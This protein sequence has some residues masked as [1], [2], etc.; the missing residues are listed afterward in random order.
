[1]LDIANAFTTQGLPVGDFFQRPNVG[2]YIP[3]YQREYSWDDGNID[4]LMEDIC[5]GVEH[6]LEDDA[7]IRFLGTIIL[8]KERNPRQNIQPQDL[9][10]LPDSIENIIDGQQRLSTIALLTCLLYEHFTALEEKIVS[11]GEE[12]SELKETIG[13]TKSALKKIFSVD[14]DRGT[15]PRKPVIIRGTKDCWTLNGRDDEFYSSD[16]SSYLAQFIT[17][18]ESDDKGFPNYRGKTLVHDN[19][20]CMNGWLT[21]VEKAHKN[22]SDD[23][24]FVPAKDILQKISEDYIWKYPRPNLIQIVSNMED[25]GT[26]SREW[27]IICSSVQLLAFTHFLLK[28]CCFTTIEPVSE[29]WAF[30]MFQSLN[31]SGTP[32]TAI[33]TF[34]PIV[35]N[36]VGTTN[37]KNSDFAKNLDMVDSFLS[38]VKT[39]EKLKLTN[40]FL[41]SFALARSGYKLANQFSEQRRWLHAQFLDCTS[42]KSKNDFIR[43][44][45]VH[46]RFYKDIA[47]QKNFSGVLKVSRNVPEEEVKLSEFLLGYLKQANHR[48]A[49]TILSRFYSSIIAE[50]EG[51]AVEFIATVKAIAAF[52]TLWRAVESNAGLDNVYRLLLKGDSERE[53]TAFSWMNNEVDISSGSLCEY[54]KSVLNDKN[55][56]SREVWIRKA[57]NYLNYDRKAICK[58]VLFLVAQDSIADPTAKG[59][60]KPAKKGATPWL[61][62]FDTWNSKDYSSLEHIAPQVAQEQSVWD[63]RIYEEE[64]QHSI[65]NLTLLPIEINSSIGNKGWLEKYY[66]YKHLSLNDFDAIS[67]LAEKARENEIHLGESTL[68]RLQEAR[69][70]HHII[71]ITDIGK[72]GKWD[73]EV[74]ESRTERICEIAWDRMAPWLSL[75]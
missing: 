41:T 44:M 42:A 66:Y 67:A 2:F 72:D 29:N 31:A 18:C 17:A 33:E 45:G 57:K 28:R 49:N 73:A 56:L 64:L 20:K 68:R 22:T 26:T 39:E 21:K 60:M 25:K 69:F 35:V 65:G 19:L 30:D 48:M 36:T 23:T 59:L 15:P 12:L 51:A 37:Y 6:L 38:D 74:I 53:I 52:F 9:R 5:R 70:N 8:V 43:Q 47:T 46:A 13:V 3:L 10:A 34:K 32:L 4:Q 61:W 27:D 16:V 11:A 7:I 14:I 24:V 75:L 54:F 62:D 71:P 58:F 55:I 1:M 63:A 40:E 50:K